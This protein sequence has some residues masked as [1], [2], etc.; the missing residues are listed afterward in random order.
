MTFNRLKDMTTG[1]LLDLIA[2]QVG[3]AY[4][5]TA[6]VIL[7]RLP[8]LGAGWEDFTMRQQ[9]ELMRITRVPDAPVA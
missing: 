2:T 3:G 1:A 9:Q 5:K 4:N 7:E 8:R 6:A